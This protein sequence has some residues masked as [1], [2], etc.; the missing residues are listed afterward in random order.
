MTHSD[1]Y[2]RQRNWNRSITWRRWRHKLANRVVIALFGIH[3]KKKNNGKTREQLGCLVSPGS[4]ETQIVATWP[5]AYLTPRSVGIKTVIST[6][7]SVDFFDYPLPIIQRNSRNNRLWRQRIMMRHVV[8]LLWLRTQNDRTA[9]SNAVSV[10][11]SDGYRHEFTRNPKSN[12]AKSQ[13]TRRSELSPS[14]HP[15]C[16]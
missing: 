14:A 12:I 4:V 9:W 3:V 15:P 11:I 6:P 16:R 8:V 13:T 7:M 1:S 10:V 5:A 2:A